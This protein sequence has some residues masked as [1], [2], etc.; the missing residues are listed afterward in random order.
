ML[1]LVDSKAGDCINSVAHYAN[2]SQLHTTMEIEPHCAHQPEYTLPCPLE[3]YQ[4]P[5]KY[6][7]LHITDT[8]KLHIGDFTLVDTHPL[9]VLVF[10][11][12]ALCL[13]TT[14]N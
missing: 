4:Q 8:L 6:R 5:L 14:S 10:V 13:V 7:Y 11:P 12:N 1:H 2:L 9:F 3:V